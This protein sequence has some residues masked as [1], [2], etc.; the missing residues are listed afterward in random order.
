MLDNE[1]D[2]TED[3]NLSKSTK[4]PIIINAE[5]KQVASYQNISSDKMEGLDE[6]NRGSIQDNTSTQDDQSSNSPKG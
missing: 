3:V 2:G 4:D 6:K 1:K 5:D